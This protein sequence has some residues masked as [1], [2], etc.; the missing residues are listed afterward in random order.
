MSTQRADM[1]LAPD[2]DPREGRPRPVG[3][4]AVLVGFLHLQRTTLE[5]KCSG[6]DAD[7]LARRSV[8]PSTMS[9]LGLVRH[10]S[11]VERAWFR[12]RLGGRGREQ[13]PL[14]YASA[15]Q[16]DGDFDGAVADPAVVEEAWATWRSECARTDAF[17]ARAPDLE[18]STWTDPHND[19]VWD[20]R[21]VLVPMVEEYARHNGHADLLRERLDGRRGQ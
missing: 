18:S 12:C 10:M 6:L 14:H 16:P 4:R 19:R 5:L 13:A 9:L 1:F 11:E 2:E 20:L 3:E 17:V 21:Q 8:P 15:S 7:A